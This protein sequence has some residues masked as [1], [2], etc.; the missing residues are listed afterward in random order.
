MD[1]PFEATDLFDVIDHAERYNRHLLEEVLAFAGGAR[2]VL[3]FGS[4]TGRLAKALA[5]R[6]FD[7][8]GVEPDPALRARLAAAGIASVAAL[9]RLA[10]RRFDYAVSVNVLEHCADDA[11]IVK[12]LHA[13]L[14]PGGRCLVYVPAFPLLWTANDVRVGHQRRYRRTGL[15]RLFREA[16]FAVA[17]VRYVDSLGFFAALAYRF[18]GRAD[19]AI[20]ARS[21][22]LYDA[23]LFPVSRLLD[24][25]LHPVIGKNLLI[26]AERVQAAAPGRRV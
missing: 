16:G 19:G 24:R 12:Q 11:G 14:A 17:D 23:L 9:D 26:R 15:V 21:V 20:D 1:R 18:V 13:R 6:G 22:R 7:V 3:D 25:A 2:A 4:G 5:E 10:D 8:T